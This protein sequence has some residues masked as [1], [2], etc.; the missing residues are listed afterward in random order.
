MRRVFAE[1]GAPVGSVCARFVNGF[2]YTRTVPLVGAR[3]SATKLPPLFVL[4]AASR[5]H[6]EFRRRTKS[7]A[8]T[9]A[10]PPGP[11]IVERWTTELKPSI[12]RRNRAF[13]AVNLAGLDD[14]AL[15]E[16]CTA[17]LEFAFENFELH[18]WL[19]GYDLGPVARFIAFTKSHG[20][21]TSEAVAA[22]VGASPSTLV[23]RRELAAIRAAV[24][25]TRPTNLVELRAASPTAAALLDAYLAERGSTLVTG[26]DLNN[27][28]LGELPESLFDSIMSASPVDE[29]DVGG[30]AI[31][32]IRALVPELHRAEYDARLSDAREV[33]DMRDDNGPTVIERP[34]GLLR[35]ALL[36]VGRRLVATGR[37]DRAEHA[38]ELAHD[39]VV[40]LVVNGHG[41][42]RDE[43]R[44]RASKRLADSRLT[45][46]QM[47]G[48]IEPVPPADIL[49]GPLAEFATAIQ[50]AMVEMGMLGPD[51]ASD[52]LSGTGVGQVT[53]RGRARCAETPEEAIDALEPGDVLVVRATSPAF[54]V[55]LAIAGAVVTADGG[56]MSH[57][58]VLARELGIAA[59]VGARGALEIPDGAIVEV[60]PGA[61]VV[62]I[63]SSV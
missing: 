57:A 52:P 60:D 41:P 30:D 38:L 43:L 6:P 17:L 9:L 5:L 18:F 1:L 37:A 32:K 45:P 36:E 56:P 34:A 48:P 3:R 51:M 49:P 50:V 15:A 44:N 20:I 10:V 23:P 63:I 21:A 27:L 33:M 4:R 2:M 13:S 7:A 29:G 53:Y 62:R 54:N 55:V 35:L 22:L 24:G 26:Y 8:H 19:H 61:G 40:P 58:A 31:R 12:D 25:D 11:A 47:L 39:E 59:V 42:T 16:H 14:I 46:P 28:T